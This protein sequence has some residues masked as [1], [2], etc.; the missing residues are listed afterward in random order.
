MPRAP[1]R[2]KKGPK[3]SMMVLVDDEMLAR[4]DKI[5]EKFGIGNRSDVV[6]QAVSRWFY[7]V[8]KIGSRHN[9]QRL[10]RPA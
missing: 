2:K 5:A 8:E 10:E 7:E 4:V 6:R 1:T 9:G 3:H